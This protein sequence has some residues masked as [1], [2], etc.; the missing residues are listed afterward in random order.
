MDC[1]LNIFNAAYSCTDRAIASIVARIATEEMAHL[2]SVQNLLLASGSAPYLGRYDKSPQEFDPFPF[3]L[4]PISPL[5]LAKYAACEK[6]ET[7][8]FLLNCTT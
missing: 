6:S 3:S 2:V 1:W 5:V 7:R 4:E 8:I